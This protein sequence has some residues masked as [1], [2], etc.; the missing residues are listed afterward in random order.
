MDRHGG[1]EMQRR[2]GLNVQPADVKERQHGQHMIVGAKPVHVL[3][4][5]AVPQQRFLAQYRAFRPSRGARG[6]DDQQ[7]A[8]EVGLRIAALACRLLHQIIE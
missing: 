3:A 8:G 1:A 5:H 7:R 6:V 2:R 4:H